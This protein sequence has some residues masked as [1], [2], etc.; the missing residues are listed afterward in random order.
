MAVNDVQDLT[1][2]IFEGYDRRW[3][4]FRTLQKVVDALVRK[5]KE[6]LLLVFKI[7]IKCAL[8]DATAS[9]GI[10]IDTL[11]DEQEKYLNSWEM[12]T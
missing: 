3:K 1:Q 4:R 12:G 11:T 7:L 5:L 2:P 8:W 6:Y 10:K 9:M